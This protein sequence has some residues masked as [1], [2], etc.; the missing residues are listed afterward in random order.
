MLD[1]LD[2]GRVQ[3]RK[4]TQQT[5]NSSI[6]AT[7]ICMRAMKNKGEENASGREN[8]KQ[9]ENECDRGQFRNVSNRFEGYGFKFFLFSISVEPKDLQDPQPATWSILGDDMVYKKLLA[10]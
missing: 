4:R 7:C 3:E 10:Q 1:N 5:R 2:F 6:K 8:R 9:V